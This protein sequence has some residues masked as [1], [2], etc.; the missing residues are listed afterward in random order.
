MAQKMPEG[1]GFHECAGGHAEKRFLKRNSAF[2]QA[3]PRVWIVLKYAIQV[4]CGAPDA[5]DGIAG[6]TRRHYGN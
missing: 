5:H 6:P 1:H 4:P 2:V 3:T